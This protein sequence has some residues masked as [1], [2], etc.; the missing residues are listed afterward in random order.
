MGSLPSRASL[1]GQPAGAKTQFAT[2]AAPQASP[3]ASAPPEA[4]QPPVRR[5]IPGGV[6]G[7]SEGGFLEDRL[8]PIGITLGAIAA[9][10]LVWALA[11]VFKL[12]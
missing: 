9:C 10:A 7:L 12:F 4:H 6:P 8:G 5:E 2:P 3:Q 11:V 1:R